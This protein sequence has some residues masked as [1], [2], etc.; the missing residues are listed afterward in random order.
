MRHKSKWT[1]II[2]AVWVTWDYLGK[3]VCLLVLGQPFLQLKPTETRECILRECEHY[4]EPFKGVFLEAHGLIRRDKPWLWTQ[5]L[6]RSMAQTQ[7]SRKC[8]WSFWIVYGRRW[9][10][11]LLWG[12]PFWEKKNVGSLI[13]H[14]ITENM[15][16]AW[17]IKQEWTL[18]G[19]GETY[20]TGSR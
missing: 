12:D 7:W 1:I 6:F 17:L 13:W 3:C 5:R 8:L 19:R 18:Y 10:G 9:V 14:E 11:V 16:T 2:R 4:K 15:P 20:H